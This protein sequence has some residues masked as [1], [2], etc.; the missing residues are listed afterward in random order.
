MNTKELQQLFMADTE[1]KLEFRFNGDH[2]KYECNVYDYK[3]KPD[4]MKSITVGGDALL[5][6]SKISAKAVSFRRWYCGKNFSITIPFNKITI[7]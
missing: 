2:V 5:F 7:E 3:G 4:V 1:A 6:I